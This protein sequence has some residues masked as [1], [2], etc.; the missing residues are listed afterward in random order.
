MQSSRFNPSLR[1]SRSNSVVV[2]VIGSI[3]MPQFGLPRLRDIGRRSGCFAIGK[4]SYSSLRPMDS[5]RNGTIPLSLRKQAEAYTLGMLRSLP[6]V[7]LVALI[8]TLPLRAQ[9]SGATF[10]GH[11]D[12]LRA[13]SGFLGQRNL[14][15]GPFPHSGVQNGILPDRFHL[16]HHARNG[17]LL[18]Y[19]LPEYDPFWYEQPETE[20]AG[21]EPAPSAVL[22]QRDDRQLGSR[23]K[24][25]PKSQ[26]I[27][28]PSAS[29]SRAAKKLP[30]TVFILQDGER[31]ESREFLLTASDL[32]LTVNHYR[33]TIPLQMLNVDAT[34]AANRERGLDLRIPADRTEISLSF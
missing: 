25:V 19:F 11:A 1:T 18:P 10:Q 16:H 6:L 31:L 23:E 28:I 20:G 13:H 26:I 2:A 3:G 29:R 24:P 14:S 27:D 34:I 30:P 12:G 5:A 21:V 4:T 17:I 32:S 7:L 8:F 9:R 22:E 33:R 15:N